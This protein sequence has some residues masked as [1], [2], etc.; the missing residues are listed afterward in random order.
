MSDK[1]MVFNYQKY[2]ELLERTRW[3]PVSE[4]LPN[5]NEDVLVDDGVDMFVAWYDNGWDS[6][7]HSCDPYTDII[8]WMPLPEP[9]KGG[10]DV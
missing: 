6:T 3:I 2:K 7:D 4:R 9:Y 8:A 1:P 5:G 10:D